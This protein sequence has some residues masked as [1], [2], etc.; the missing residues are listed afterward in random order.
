MYAYRD[1][2]SRFLA[3]VR[4]A[5]RR[6]T[7]IDPSLRWQ[8]LQ[9]NAMHLSIPSE[10]VDA[11]I[12]SPPYFGALDYGRDNRLRL[13]FLGVENYKELESLLT[14]NNRV[15]VPQ[16]TEAV[17][18]MYR[19]LKTNKAAVLVLGDYRRN[20][21][22]ADSAETIAEIAQQRLPHKLIVEDIVDDA[23]PD[24]RRSRRRTRTT[25]KERVL[26]LRKLR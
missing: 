25:S 16:M 5:Y 4:R 19:V 26:V 6:Y 8:V 15:Y 10:S 22:H 7:P 11:I 1:I 14:S 18:E 12:S 24:E 9:E 2:R 13:W 3:K 20:G 21:K 23:I 17:K